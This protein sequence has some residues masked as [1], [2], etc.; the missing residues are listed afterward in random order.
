M[1]SWPMLPVEAHASSKSLAPKCTLSDCL[2]HNPLRPITSHGR[3]FIFPL[4]TTHTHTLH[5]FDNT[6]TQLLIT[7][8]TYAGIVTKKVWD[9]VTWNLLPTPRQ[10]TLELDHLCL[11]TQK[12]SLRHVNCESCRNNQRQSIEF[13]PDSTESYSLTAKHYKKGSGS[14]RA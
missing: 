14:R 9:P 12:W 7:A 1:N 10:D 6:G 4:R 11:Y 8:R 2:L 3:R 13:F 5:T